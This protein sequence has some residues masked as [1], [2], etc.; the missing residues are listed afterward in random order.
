MSE[1]I[2]KRRPMVDMEEFERRLRKPLAADQQESDLLAELARFVGGQEDPYKSVFEPL[3]RR[4]A[5]GS[6]GGQ[7]KGETGGRGPQEPLIR[8]DFAAIEAGLLGAA[9]QADAPGYSEAI[10]PSSGHEAF[11]IHF[12]LESITDLPGL[13]ELKGAGLFDGR[14]PEDFGIPQPCDDPALTEDEDPLDGDQEGAPQGAE[15]IACGPAMPVEQ[16]DLEQGSEAAR[17]REAGP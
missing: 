16:A 9:Q 10:E 13:E 4:P 6:R 11:L 7:D 3:N 12:G 5:G 1:Q 2:V 8:G 15:T 14:L 17:E